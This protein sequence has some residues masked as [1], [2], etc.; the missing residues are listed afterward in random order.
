[1]QTRAELKN[2]FPPEKVAAAAILPV[3]FWAGTGSGYEKNT[4]YNFLGLASCRL[5]RAGDGNGFGSVVA[6]S[7][8]KIEEGR[9]FTVAESMG[10]VQRASR[11][12]DQ[13]LGNL[14]GLKISVDTD[15]WKNVQKYL[16]EIHAKL[17]K[18]AF[19]HV[20]AK[21]ARV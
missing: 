8:P 18:Q 3:Y 2:N 9:L 21:E 7:K 1:M 11:H 10:R 16:D 14:Q 20:E 13:T 5:C 6:M 15:S 4:E 12:I 17:E 19:E